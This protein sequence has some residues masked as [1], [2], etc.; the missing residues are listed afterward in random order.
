[1]TFYFI[2]LAMNLAPEH[3]IQVVKSL[4]KRVLLLY[5]LFVLIQIHTHNT[6]T[7]V[8]FHV[9]IV[10]VVKVN[11]NKIVNS[12][13][14]TPRAYTHFQSFFRCSPLSLTR[15]PFA[16][17]VFFFATLYYYIGETGIIDAHT[18]IFSVATLKLTIRTHV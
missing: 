3:F 5:F 6:N 1:M 11:L 8:A 9:F 10:V 4:K 14:G 15:S 2:F 7:W 16:S 18:H 17:F 12:G 13:H